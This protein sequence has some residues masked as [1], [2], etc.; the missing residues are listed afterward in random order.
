MRNFYEIEYEDR[1]SIW[2]DENPITI[3]HAIVDIDKIEELSL[4]DRIIVGSS[5]FYQLTEE[6]FKRLVDSI[7]LYNRPIVKLYGNE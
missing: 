1:G 5:I 6:S 4:E 2:D 3:K 7:K